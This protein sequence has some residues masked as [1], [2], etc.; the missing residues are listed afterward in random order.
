MVEYANTGPVRVAHV[1][2]G[3]ETG[4][5]E[6]L[7]VEFAR[8]ADR[9]TFDL[10]F[11]SLG[12]R[13][14]LAADL[15]ECGWP[16]HP[17]EAATKIR[18]GL[19][20]RLAVQFR[21][22]GIHVVHTHE[23]RPLIHAAPAARLAGVAAV[24]HTRHGQSVGLTRRQKRLV[25]WASWCANRFV[26][27]SADSARRARADGIGSQR[28]ATI[29]NG[30]DLQRYRYS[31]PRPDGP[32]VCV[33]RLSPEK[34][35]E[36]LIA[37]A[38]LAAR[39][40]PNF[41]LVIGGDGPSLPALRDQTR[42]LG[43]DERVEFLGSVRDVPRLLQQCAL[44][45]LP[46]LTEGI[47]LTLLE[48]MATGLPVVATRVGGTSEVVA[49]GKTGLLVPSQCPER[50]AEA[51][52]SLFQDPAAARLMGQ[53]GRRR[54]ESAFDVRTMVAAYEALYRSCGRGLPALTGAAAPSQEMD[55]L[56][57]AW[58]TAHFFR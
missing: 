57:S 56:A 41:R 51:M 23:D 36:S 19:V 30:I 5:Q 34:N 44:F 35:V 55:R 24:V 33:A 7:L 42:A 37:A 8:H 3:L 12:G 27:V 13:G 47:A 52:L 58:E 9:H 48:A 54:V 15:E 1:T 17:L 43:L 50:L 32:V 14:A 28:V 18:P 40:Q 4:G 53:A 20:A 45:V 46:S 11:I 16:V 39:A 10:R 21:R 22:W 29:R 49:D 25:R 31:G 6:K 38:G 26:C 2:Q